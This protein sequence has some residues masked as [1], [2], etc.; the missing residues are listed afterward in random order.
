[1]GDHGFEK[2]GCSER[3]VERVRV[4]RVAAGAE[5][6]GSGREVDGAGLGEGRRESRVD[7][8]IFSDEGRLA[9]EKCENLEGRKRFSIP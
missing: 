3:T 4:P 6:G 8:P 1:M 5:V 9:E 7:L 2:E